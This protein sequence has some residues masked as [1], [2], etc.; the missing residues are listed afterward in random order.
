MI[1][2]PEADA[3]SLAVPRD[4]ASL[5]IVDGSEAKLKI[6]LG[7]RRTTQAF[8]PGNYVFPGGGLDPADSLHETGARLPE[9]DRIALAHDPGPTSAGLSPEAFAYAAIRETFEETGLLI[10]RP[11]EPPVAARSVGPVPSLGFVPDIGALTFMARAITPPGRAKRFDARFFLAD[12][13]AISHRSTVNDGEFEDIAWFDVSSAMALNLHSMTREIL[14]LAAGLHPLSPME[15]LR[16]PIPYFFQ[17]T[18]G[19]QRSQ[20]NR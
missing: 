12:A 13:A 11:G 3:A 8:A 19:W 17:G 5:V 1:A 10:G 2:K 6:L 9:P 4:A 7:K 15:R 18:D 20:I 14:A 16:R